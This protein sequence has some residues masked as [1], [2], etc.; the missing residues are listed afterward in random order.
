[1]VEGTGR[2]NEEVGG[3]GHYLAEMMRLS[4]PAYAAHAAERLLSENPACAERFGDSAFADWQA[5][6][7][8]RLNELAIAVELDEPALFCSQVEWTRDAFVARS[9]PVE[10]VA[11][12]L[13]SLHATLSSEL[14]EG[15]ADMPGPCIKAALEILEEETSVL[16]PGLEDTEAGRIARLYVDAAV[17]GDQRGALATVLGAVEDGLPVASA[18]ERVLLPAEQEIGRMWHV[19]EIGIAEEHAA[20]TTA[21]IAMSALACRAPAPAADAPLVLLAGVEGD[22]HDLGIRATAALLEI[23]GCRSL[24]LGTDVP[25]T[26]IVRAVDETGP[27]CVI[28]SASLVTHL[29]HLRRAIR[30][31]RD[32]DLT[33][34]PRIL[35]AGAALAL[36]PH[37]AERLEADA[38]VASPGEAVRSAQGL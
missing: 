4:A 24:S 36:A 15:L 3:S 7:V 35:V 10:D 2:M 19:G 32:A 9:L 20:T 28:L 14:P 37:L 30:R 6:L 17:A 38:H 27:S 1:M 5:T 8:Q 23:G 16:S 11:R 21:C 33:P 22:R 31:V 18:V 13:E 25:V 29:H 34:V 12:S 26:E